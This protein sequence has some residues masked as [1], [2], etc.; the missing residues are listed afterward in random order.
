MAG[1]DIILGGLLLFG[2]VRGLWKGLFIE[3]ASLVSLIAGVF[4]AVKFS[5][6]TA[7]L[8]EG[9]VTDDPATAGVIAFAIT[10]LAVVIGIIL[11]GKVFTKLAESS[12]L[13]LMNRIL[14]GVFGLMKMALIL[15]VVLNFF[16][17][18]NFD[19]NFIKKETLDGSLL[20][21]PLLEV[22]AYIFPV[23]EDWFRD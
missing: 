1:I 6:L 11:L 17:K 8:L 22:S 12:G 4:I 19:H 18:L 20:F 23:F 13:G 16:M 10:F 9:S 21:Y 15:S 2:L 7:S 3:L 5:Q 14:G